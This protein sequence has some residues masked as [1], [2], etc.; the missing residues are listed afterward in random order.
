MEFII[1]FYLFEKMLLGLSL[2]CSTYFASC[3]V[4]LDMDNV[5]S[6]NNKKKKN[7]RLVKQIKCNISMIKLVLSIFIFTMIK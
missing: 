4:S 2:S 7:M 5:F 3:D 1:L 6:L